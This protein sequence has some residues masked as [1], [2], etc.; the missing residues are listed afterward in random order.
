MNE[1]SRQQAFWAGVRDELPILVGTIP[2]GLIY[3]VT[4]VSLGVPAGIAQAMSSIVFAGSA[5]FVSAQLIG[6]SAPAVIVVLTAVIINLRHLLYSASLAPYLDRLPLRWKAPLAYLLTDEAYAVTIIHFRTTSD[7]RYRHWYYLGAGLALWSTWQTAT[8]AGVFLGAQVPASWQLDFTLPLTFIALVVVAIRDRA[9]VGTA[10]VAALTAVVAF[11][12]PFKTGLIVAT[13]LGIAA[14]LAFDLARPLA[15][16]AS[17]TATPPEET[18]SGEQT[19][20][21]DEM[22]TR[23][24]GGR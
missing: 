21:V 15:A 3:G 22:A 18:A 2:F 12:F 23:Q 24:Q 20:P 6:A 11:G 17:R 10:V 16:D 7:S 13:M 9:S 4:A 1:Q 19:P 8:A 5:Q 14:G